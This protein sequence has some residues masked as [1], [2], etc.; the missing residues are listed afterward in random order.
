MPSMGLFEIF[1][2]KG[3]VPHDIREVGAVLQ[4]LLSPLVL[5]LGLVL[6][7]GEG[8]TSVPTAPSAHLA[9]AQSLLPWAVRA[10]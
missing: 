9:P 8:K 1:L 3:L 2:G 4:E 6:V 5:K 7:L 10:S